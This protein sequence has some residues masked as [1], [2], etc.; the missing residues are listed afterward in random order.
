MEIFLISFYKTT[1]TLKP[2]QTKKLQ[3]ENYRSN[4]MNKYAKMFNKTL[5]NQTYTSLMSPVLEVGS[6][7]LVPPGNP[8]SIKK[9]I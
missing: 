1:I 5:R 9:G 4:T 3:T 8:Y 7:P 2:N 6:L